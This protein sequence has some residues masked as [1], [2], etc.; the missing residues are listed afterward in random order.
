MRVR[1]WS[2]CRVRA[3]FP[4]DLA[5][6]LDEASD[7][8][9]MGVHVCA[10]SWRGE[11]NVPDIAQVRPDLLVPVV[12][13]V[14]MAAGGHSLEYARR[15]NVRQSERKLGLMAQ[16]ST[17]ASFDGG[18]RRPDDG[19]EL[20]GARLATCPLLIATLGQ[21]L[22]GLITGGETVWR[23]PTDGGVE[24]HCLRRGE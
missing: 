8:S 20:S 6:P 7:V 16:T 3:A 23:G 2:R 15:A 12:A 14:P 11:V 4:I 10:R 24:P 1:A 18:V 13:C 9:G 19:G 5:S 22:A 21:A 17:C